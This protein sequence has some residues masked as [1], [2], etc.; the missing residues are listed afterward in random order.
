MVCIQYLSLDPLSTGPS[1]SHRAA[2]DAHRRR[3]RHRQDDDGR[4]AGEPAEERRASVRS[5]ARPT[6]SAPRPSSSSR[7]G[8]RARAW[9]SCA[10]AKGADPAAVVFDAISSGKATGPRSDSRRHGGPAAHARQPDERAR[11]DPPHRRARGAGRAAG[12]AARARRDRRPERP[13]RRRASSRASP[14]STASC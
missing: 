9:T 8:R 1:S 5:S 6:R 12:S 2:R 13:A 14:A 3:Q 4:Q 10:R 7:S 11:E